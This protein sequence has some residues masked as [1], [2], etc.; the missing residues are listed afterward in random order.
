MISVR[1]SEY[2]SSYE[3]VGVYTCEKGKRTWKNCVDT[4]SVYYRKLDKLGRKQYEKNKISEL[5][6]K[7]EI[8]QAKLELWNSLK[9]KQGT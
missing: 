7:D 2:R 5:V 4:N 1:L 8:Y 6:T 9:P 3:L